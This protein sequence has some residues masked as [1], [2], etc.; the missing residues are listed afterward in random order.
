MHGQPQPAGGR[1]VRQHKL[2]TGASE[3]PAPH[4]FVAHLSSGDG[5]LDPEVE[6]ITVCRDDLLVSDLPHGEPIG[7]GRITCGVVCAGVGN[8]AAGNTIGHQCVREALQQMADPRRPR[9]QPHGKA[10][11]GVRVGC[12]DGQAHVGP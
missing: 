1:C 7:E 12:S 4:E 11:G 3:P 10:I 2:V 5:K 6:A 8:H 9:A